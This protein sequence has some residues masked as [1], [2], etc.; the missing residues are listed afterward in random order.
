VA[1]VAFLLDVW[2]Y[3]G[4]LIDDTFISLRYARNWVEGHGLVFNRGEPVE[5]YTNFS[6]VVL[7]ALFLRL[8]VDPI[9]GTKVVSGCMALV[10]LFVLARMERAIRELPLSRGL[11]PLSL[12][13]L[14]PVEG[15]AYWAVASFETMLFTG[16]LLLGLYALVRE[17]AR[18]SGHAAALFFILLALTR[19]EGVALFVV[20]NS[21]FA[22]V[23]MLRARSVAPIRRYAVNGAV[24]AAGFLPYFVWRCWYYGRLLPNTFYAKV[25]G[26]W[27]QLHTGL[28]H[29]VD[30]ILAV[31]LLGLALILPAILIVRRRGELG[32][33]AAIYL[34][35]LAHVS[36]VILVG[37]DFMPFFRFLLPVLPLCALLLA[38]GL[39]QSDVSRRHVLVILTLAMLVTLLASHATEQSYRAFVA[40]RT[41]EVGMQTGKW[42][43]DHLD[44]NDLIAVNTAGAV[45]YASRLPAI[46]ML[47]LTD[48][49][50]ASRQVFI[51]STGWAGHRKG[52]GDYV[53]ARRPRV[54]LWYNSAG[55]REPF[56][57][58]DHELADSSLFRFFYRPMTATLPDP[59]PGSDRLELFL[60]N[61]FEVTSI[62]V[63]VS[64]DLGLKAVLLERPFPYTEIHGHNV[65][66]SY[67]D[68][69]AR[70]L[71]LW[72]DQLSAFSSPPSAFSDG[73]SA[74]LLVETAVQAWRGEKPSITGDA[75]AIVAV[76]TLCDEARLHV[77]SGNYNAA[78]RALS[79]AAQHNATVRSPI[80]YQYI[81]NVAVLT[82][83]L[84][85]AVGAQ[86][87]ALRLEPENRLYQNNLR[88]LLSQPYKEFRRSAER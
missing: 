29:G 28:T 63:A 76:E 26:G 79:E 77:E 43:A 83:D 22:L 18:A 82:G 57:L 34:I 50:I 73:R 41:T 88:R 7:S 64:P 51:V 39:A 86:K 59:T 71:A 44:P 47:G 61:P 40:H 21:S 30:A 17:S 70:D 12:L 62:G 49:N 87:E 45:P 33:V 24:F 6:F 48:Q 14:L 46:D 38:W 78:R 52:W 16:L 84:F 32:P 13:F 11:P 25:T 20:C 53:L 2:R 9:A 66:M 8:G 81:A 19:P 23:E 54:I 56:Y 4:F 55:S 35:V 58:G 65:T 15:F 10:V 68:L 75:E 74:S 72:R 60:G 27:E 42:L 1:I 36:Y 37:G 85:L 80:V 31:P 69:D 5:G 3:S 67:F